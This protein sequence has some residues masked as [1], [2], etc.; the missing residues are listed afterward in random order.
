MSSP[1]RGG[2]SL[3]N[4]GLPPPS[5]VSYA[6]EGAVLGWRRDPTAY[7]VGYALPPA[8]GL[9]K[10]SLHAIRLC[11]YGHRAELIDIGVT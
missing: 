10:P 4:G 8:S 1:V 6:P 3:R 11:A 5:Q 7:A 9:A 2:R